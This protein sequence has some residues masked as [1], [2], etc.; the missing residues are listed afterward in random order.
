VAD[1]RWFKDYSLERVRDALKSFAGVLLATPSLVDYFR[2]HRLHDR[3]ILYP[4]VAQ[5][6]LPQPGR[7]DAE[8]VTVGFFGG[9]HRREPFLRFVYPA[10]RR[11]AQEQPIRLV[12][13]GIDR[14]DLAMDARLPAE[15]LDYDPSYTDGLSAMASRGIDVLAHPGSVHPHN[16]FKNT[17]VLI[18]ANA[19]GAVPVFSAGPPY[20]EIASSEIAL[21]CQ[22]TEDAWYGALRRVASDAALRQTVRGRLTAYCSTHFNGRDNVEVIARLLREHAAPAAGVRT[23]R[24]L[25]GMPLHGVSLAQHVVT[26]MTE[27][28]SA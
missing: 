12:A 7:R 16:A 26:R 28:Y 22:N 3:L 18:N 10:L 9:L 25:L 17:H 2:T 15:V 14:R 19:I 11:L 1:A 27:K 13:A 5:E 23:M 8:A 24:L 21:L 4:P 6:P 20:D